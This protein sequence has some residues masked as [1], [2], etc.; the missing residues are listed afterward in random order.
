MAKFL[1]RLID[2]EFAALNL[3]QQ[4]FYLF[5][6]NMSSPILPQKPQLSWLRRSSVGCAAR[7]PKADK[8]RLSFIGCVQN[9]PRLT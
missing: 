3:L 2:I 7:P 5:L 6:L 1:N 9:N 8:F 4:L